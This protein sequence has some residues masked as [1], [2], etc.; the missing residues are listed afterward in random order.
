MFM[1]HYTNKKHNYRTIYMYTC[2]PCKSN[3]DRVSS[4]S[5]LFGLN[6]N[7]CSCL[8]I[9]TLFLNK[10]KW[11]QLPVWRSWFIHT[12]FLPKSTCTCTVTIRKVQLL[13]LFQW[14]VE[15]DGFDCLYSTC[16]VHVLY[17]ILYGS[18]VKPKL[19]F[20]IYIY[21]WSQDIELIF[22]DFPCG[23]CLELYPQPLH[24]VQP[25]MLLTIHNFPNLLV[26]VSGTSL[27]DHLF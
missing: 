4:F 20:T 13:N 27:S 12:Q 24:V 7:T 9:I 16:T 5:K 3:H 25:C 11:S 15:D 2:M 8:K 18:L 26:I 1:C 10:Q 6:R 17:T 19:T 22:R 21:K 23:T 14:D